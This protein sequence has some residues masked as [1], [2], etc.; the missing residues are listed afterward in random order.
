M[1]E[2]SEESLTEF[3]EILKRE[4][5]SLRKTTVGNL[6]CLILALVLLFRT[7]RG[8]YGR[9]T[10]SGIARCFPA[11]GTGKSRYK[12][13]ARFLDNGNF[14]MLNLTRDLVR[15]IY[16]QE[17]LLPVIIDQTAIGDIQDDLKRMFLRK[18]EAFLWLFPPS[19]IER[20]KGVKTS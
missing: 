5:P 18:E 10:L 19:N 2:A 11:E 3:K 17:D 15:L 6:A 7:Y 8:W 16:P 20:S 14:R 13:L 9:L 1:K 12:R 4:F